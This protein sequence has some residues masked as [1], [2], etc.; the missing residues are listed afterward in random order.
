LWREEFS[1]A[2]TEQG[3]VERRQFGRFLLLTSGAMFAGQL[4]LVAKSLFSKA[5]ESA[6]PRRAIAA[7]SEIAPGGTKVFQYPAQGDDCL[8]VRLDENRFAAYS[9]KCTHLSC[10]VIYAP[11]TGRL[12]CPC[13][14]GYFSIADGHVLQGPPARPLPKIE[15]EVRDGQVF[16]TGISVFGQES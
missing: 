9:Q 13:H 14:E 7:A 4:W 5:A 12:E 10:A 6:W 15:L 8:L 16:A 2:A 3:Y 1:V 11:E